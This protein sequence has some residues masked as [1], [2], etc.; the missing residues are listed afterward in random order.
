MLN[1]FLSPLSFNRFG[2]KKTGTDIVTA[3]CPHKPSVKKHF[4]LDFY[5][6]LRPYCAIAPM[7]KHLLYK[8][9]PIL[10]ELVRALVTAILKISRSIKCRPDIQLLMTD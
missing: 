9:N 10:N 7:L 4:V 1:F 2:S 8:S 5:Y 3:M 6:I